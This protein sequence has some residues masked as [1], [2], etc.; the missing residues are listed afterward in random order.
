E[1]ESAEPDFTEPDFTEPDFTET[2]LTES[3][4][5][6]PEPTGLTPTQPDFSEPEPNITPWE[7][8]PREADSFADAEPGTPWEAATFTDEVRAEER[9]GAG[10]E[11][12]EEA[13]GHGEALPNQD[14][15]L[16]SNGSDTPWDGAD[17][18]YEASYANPTETADFAGP[19]PAGVSLEETETRVADSAAAAADAPQP[20]AGEAVAPQPSQSGWQDPAPVTRVRGFSGSGIVLR[21]D[22]DLSALQ[23]AQQAVSH[24]LGLTETIAPA[25]FLLR[26]AAR[27]GRPW[28]LTTVDAAPSL[29]TLTD[30][31]VAV[32]YLPR[33]SD[34]PFRELVVACSAPAGDHDVESTALVVADLS[35]L[36][37]DEAV[38]DL[39]RPVLTLGR[40]LP[41]VPGDRF[42][43][44]LALSGPIAP[45][46]G[47]RFLARVVE[48][49]A[50]PVR[51]V[52]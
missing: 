19:L 12:Q 46:A 1:L 16:D 2:N 33:A 20:A 34:M 47:S 40:I 48:L 45:D 49:L 17:S 31:G 15:G 5:T 24:E 22:V 36:G 27:A 28:P 3:D 21:R 7:T 6:E 8:Q 29:A 32:T 10:G 51:L 50:A 11:V 43:G 42:R 26:A 18:S 44:T 4:L 39:G 35:V 14:D 38:L 13:H 9:A 41:Q 52:L 30:D 23:Q 37:I 25:S